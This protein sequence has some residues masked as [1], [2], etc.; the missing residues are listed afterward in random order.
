MGMLPLSLAR[1]REPS[2]PKGLSEG[3]T[4]DDMASSLPVRGHN[5]TSISRERPSSPCCREIDSFIFFSLG[6]VLKSQ[7]CLWGANKHVSSKCHSA[8]Y[9]NGGNVN[10]RLLMDERLQRQKHPQ[11]SLVDERLSLQSRLCSAVGGTH[12]ILGQE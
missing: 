2:K 6:C 9:S 5:I 10:Q 12:R 4:N 7:G 11:G 1:K 3:S 8:D